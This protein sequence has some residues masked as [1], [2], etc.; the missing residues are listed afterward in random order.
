V[1]TDYEQ[2]YVGVAALSLQVFRLGEHVRLEV[3]GQVAKH[4]GEQ[5]HWELNALVIG[6][7]V[8]FPWNT[9]LHTTFAIGEGI[10][11]ATEVPKLEGRRGP[12]SG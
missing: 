2:S 11:Y 9:Y 12:R 7:W 6:R 3:E 5:H 4:F 1:G 8:T 10:S